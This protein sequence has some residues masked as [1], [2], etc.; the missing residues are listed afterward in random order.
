MKA[1]DKNRALR[2]INYQKN[3]NTYIK[4]LSISLSCLFLLICIILITFAKFESVQEFNLIKGVI[5]YSSCEYQPGKTWDFPFDTNGDGKGQEQVF[6]VPCNGDYKLET[7]GAQGGFQQADVSQANFSGYGGY[8]YGSTHAT[9]SDKLYINV[10]GQGVCGYNATT[11]LLSGGYNGGGS[12]FAGTSSGNVTCSGGGATHIAKHSGLLYTLENKKGSILMVAGGGGG[13][14]PDDDRSG[15]GGGTLGGNGAGTAVCNGHGATQS[16]LRDDSNC[17]TAGL[18]CFGRGNSSSL[19]SG[20][21]GGGYFGGDN[22]ASDNA[23]AYISA[24]HSCTPFTSHDAHGTNMWGA[25]GGGGS[26]YLKNTLTDSGFY[27]Y[28][29]CGGEKTTVV[30]TYASHEEKKANSGNGYARITYLGNSMCN[31]GEYIDFGF[32]G[33][34]QQF[35]TSCSGTYK[36][37]LWGAQGG[38]GTGGSSSSNPANGYYGSYTSGTIDLNKKESL[39]IFVGEKGSDCSEGAVGGYNGG[40]TGYANNCSYGAGG[41]GGATDVR[42]FEET[43]NSS[44]LVWNSNIGL[45]SRIMVAGGGGGARSG[46]AGGGITGYIY[47]SSTTGNGTQTSGYNFG[48]SETA[49]VKYTASGGGG[50]YGGVKP[51]EEYTGY[52]SSSFIS[53]HTGC[54]AIAKNSNSNPRQVIKQGCVSKTNDNSCS[55]HYSGKIFD[56]TIMIDGK[57]CLWNNDL[58]SNC[59]NMP[60]P[61]GSSATGLAGNGHA[62]ITIV[63][64]KNN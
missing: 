54:V 4:R 62:R 24:N 9:Q 19:L 60:L 11:Y 16:G 61:D 18:K 3:R 2:K 15:A 55:H 64:L 58:T 1:F 21:G 47:G 27:C 29:G 17:T 45:N 40:G 44:D 10:G 6:T 30:N 56:N 13:I 34:A 14:G 41:G 35:I 25:G 20:A 52:G 57:G 31:E 5:N 49:T 23:N 26:G 50:Y 63:S 37:E 7:W 48:Y 28:T 8:A 39:Y 12:S 46:V 42:Y 51:S 38:A 59:D 53:G 32:T 22:G 33:S 43:P 36:I